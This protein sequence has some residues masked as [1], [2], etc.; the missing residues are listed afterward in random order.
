MEDIRDDGRKRGTVRLE[1]I[2]EPFCYL[3]L[4]IAPDR[5]DHA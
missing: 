5:A 1:D 3:V 2:C 4:V